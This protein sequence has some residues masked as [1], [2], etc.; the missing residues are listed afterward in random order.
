ML[1]DAPDTVMAGMCGLQSNWKFW[2]NGHNVAIVEMN[3]NHNNNKRSNQS[4]FMKT[5]I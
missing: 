5:K 2:D 1:Q 3:G 4:Y